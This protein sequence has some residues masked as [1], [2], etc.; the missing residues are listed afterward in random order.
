MKDFHF[1]AA[2][3]SMASP[4][5]SEGDSPDLTYGQSQRGDDWDPEDDASSYDPS[6]R[7]GSIASVGTSN[8]S[9][10]SYYSEVGSC[11]EPGYHLEMR[12]GS[13][14][15]FSCCHLDDIVLTLSLVTARPATSF[16]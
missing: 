1:G 16:I 3:S 12:R 4:A 5:E 8:S 15:V 9:N 2:S 11:D 7:F 14:Y 10:T 13:S 6:L